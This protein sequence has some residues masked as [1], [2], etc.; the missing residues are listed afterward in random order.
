M[1]LLIKL[2]QFSLILVLIMSVIGPATMTVA[3]A[4]WRSHPVLMRIAAEKPEQT[5]SVIVQM[6]AKDADMES[7]VANLGGQITKDLH[8][9]NAYAVELPV[10]SAVELARGPNV[11]WVSLD[12]AVEDSNKGKGGGKNKDTDISEPLP[13]NYFLDTLGVR[14][15]W[16]NGLQGEGI[17]VA[18]IDSG[19]FMDRDFS[20]G[21][22]R[23]GTRILWQESFSANSFKTDDA[24]GHGTHVAG[25]IGGHGG[26]SDGIY[27]G[28]APSV[29]LINLKV[30]DENG[31]AYESDVVAAMQWIY[32]NKDQYIIRVVNLSL[33]STVESSYHH[34][35][36]DAAAEIL[37]F[38]GVV[39]VA[40]A[41]NKG[42]GGGFNTSNAAPANDP[43]IITVGATD[44]MGTSNL[45]DDIFAPFSAF[46]VTDNGYFKPEIVAP[47]KDIVSVLSASSNWNQDYPERIIMNGEYFR[48]SGTSMAAPM[49]SGAVALLLQ[50]EPDLTPDQVK[51]RLLNASNSVLGEVDFDG[52]GLSEPSYLPY[53]DVYAMVLG[54]S[55][56]ESA[57]TGIPVSKLLWTGDES[58]SWNSVAWN[59]VAWNSVAWNSVA[60]NSVAWNSVAWNSVAWND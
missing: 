46:G 18:V 59:S 6:M 36:M 25:I 8:I 14:Q 51:Y 32:D 24:T 44:E 33:N 1:K 54:S 27:S 3:V 13:E 30:S 31:V 9:I 11:R 16:S 43:F 60:W 12:A 10:E 2:I 5:V 41:G 58:L 47:G 39:V 35:P 22:K 23:K 50:D 29:N 19:V 21:S 52:D 53:L 4:P 57:N 7:Y 49:V 28:V 34:S 15:V 26:A 56:N 45:S 55:T 17:A 40:A 48:L 20:I 38:N 42:P 37:W